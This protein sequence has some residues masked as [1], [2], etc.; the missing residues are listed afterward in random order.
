M[1]PSALLLS[2]ILEKVDLS[3]EETKGL[4]NNISFNCFL[5]HCQNHQNSEFNIP[6]TNIVLSYVNGELFL[7][8]NYN[9]ILLMSFKH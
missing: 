8:R 4:V 6:R 7:R 5:R 1:I 9:R 2:S 3:P